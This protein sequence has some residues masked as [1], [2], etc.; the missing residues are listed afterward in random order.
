MSAGIA[1]HSVTQAAPP[2]RRPEAAQPPSSSAAPASPPLASWVSLIPGGVAS[3]LSGGADW[4]SR[5]AAPAAPASRTCRRGRPGRHGRRAPGPHG[6]PGR[7]SRRGAR[8]WSRSRRP[9]AGRCESRR[10]G[11]AGT[12][13]STLRM[14]A[15]SWRRCPGWPTN[16][17]AKVVVGEQPVAFL[18]QQPVEA[19]RPSAGRRAPAL[20]L[21]TG[22]ASLRPDRHGEFEPDRPMVVDPPAIRSAASSARRPRATWVGPSSGGRRRRR[23]RGR[24]SSRC[25]EAARRHRPY[26]PGPSCAPGRG[27]A[28]ARSGR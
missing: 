21:R 19:N 6:R 7:P 14:A 1:A 20:R 16:R 28:P 8:R 2:I 9:D 17:S 25:C 26:A 10:R 5:E 12:A 3:D 15:R 23:N 4:A 27:P 24:G 13:A 22:P 18:R 11:W